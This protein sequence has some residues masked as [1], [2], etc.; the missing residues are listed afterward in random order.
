MHY[1]IYQITCNKSGKIYIGKHQ[2]KNLDDG[3]M[4]S[5]KILTSAQKK[6]GLENFKKDILF[7]FDNEE[8][9]NAKE[10]ELVTEAF[11][12]REDTYNICPG[13]KGGWGYINQNSLGLNL[14]ARDPEIMAKDRAK[15]VE[16][17]KELYPQ[18]PLF[19][20]NH[21]DETKYK[22]SENVKKAGDRLK[23]WAGYFWITNKI[24]NKRVKLDS[25]IP[26]GWE[27]G[28]T[29]HNK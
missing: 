6:Y 8:E 4:G 24:N 23:P 16:R 15:G 18:G 14:N 2:T 1:T 5:G 17:I 20:K 25:E 9:M 22:I 28:R 10:A 21:S 12:L 26:K 11:C 19:G 7:I 13:G 3:Y 27:R 29:L